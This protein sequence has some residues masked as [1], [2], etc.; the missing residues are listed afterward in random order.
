MVV[1]AHVR[2]AEVVTHGEGNDGVHSDGIDREG[3][4]GDETGVSTLYVA[5][6]G[7]NDADRGDGEDGVAEARVKERAAAG[8]GQL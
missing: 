8:D 7:G 4:V 3:G 6:G 2:M 5:A 1:T